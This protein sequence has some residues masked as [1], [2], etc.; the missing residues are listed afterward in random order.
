MT[1]KKALVV[2]SF[3]STFAE[4][5]KHDIGG[6]EQAIANAF[7]EYDQYRAFT[8]AIVRKRLAAQNIKV[9]S[10]EETLDQLQQNGY[11]EIIIQPTH[12]LSGEEFEQ[13]VLAL[14]EIYAN[15]FK[16]ILLGNPLISSEEDYKQIAAALAK[17]F[18]PLEEN[19]GVIF[20][21]H[22][23]P[24]PNNKTF[25]HTYIKLQEIFDSMQLPVLV[26]T[27]EDED[28]PNFET[29]LNNLQKRCYAKVHL[30]PL[31]VVAGDHANND[32]YGDNP[33]SW[34]ARIE[35]IGIATEGHLN[36]IGRYKAIQNLY[37]QH[38]VQVLSTN[39]GH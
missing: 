31:M 26:G 29:V 1:K 5:R 3:G 16:K 38:I 4:T 36:G 24:R 33:E 27:V 25:H 14:T 10:L 30:Y 23:T 21:G 35:A 13:K 34:K 32:M 19:E 2:V 28:A 12:L 6:I 15:N 11:E 22:G 39:R 9:Q 20:M 8:S 7:P 17:Q 18:P 37:I